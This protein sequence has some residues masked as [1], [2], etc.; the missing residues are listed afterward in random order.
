M[1]LN[2]PEGITGSKMFSALFFF[3]IFVGYKKQYFN[4]LNIPYNQFFYLCQYLNF[5]KDNNIINK[6]ISFG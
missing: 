2:K 1:T 5:A 6:S 4:E 3:G